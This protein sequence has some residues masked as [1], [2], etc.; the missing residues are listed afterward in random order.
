MKIYL[1]TGNLNKKREVQEL[2]PEHTVVIPKD[3]GI[4]FDPEE[5]G[6]TFYENSLIKAKAL[7]DMVHCPVLADDSGICVD[8]LDGAPGIYSS[9]YAGPDFMKGKPDVTKI[10]QDEQNNFIVQQTSDAIKAGYAGGRKAHYTCAMVLYMG[11]D[12]LF[13]CQET[14]EGEII[15]DISNARGTGGFGYDPLFYLPEF[16]KTAAELT[17]DEKNAISHRGKASRLLKKLA[18]NLLSTK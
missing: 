17:A 11:P 18:E 6:T 2:F 5:T 1:A 16:G 12:R 14:M 7:W 4:T 3:E 13:V 9:R 10:S 15:D 8:A